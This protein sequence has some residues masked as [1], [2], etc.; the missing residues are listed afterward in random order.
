MDNWIGEGRQEWKLWREEL[1][2]GKVDGSGRLG[3]RR[4]TEV[5]DW[6]EEGQRKWKIG[7]EKVDRI[8]RL[9]GEDID[10]SGRLGGRKLTE[11]EDWGGRKIDGSGS[12]GG[13]RSTEME[14]WAGEGRWKWKTG[15]EKVDGSGRQRGRRSNPGR[16]KGV[17]LQFFRV[18]TCARRVSF[19]STNLTFV[20]TAHNE[21]TSWW[22]LCTLYSLACQVRVTVGSRGPFR[23]S[24]TLFKR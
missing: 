22:C 23:V 18:N 8:G 24:V 12:L 16:D 2:Q 19:E 14:D 9:G 13:R 15:R 20:C 11:V 1:G 3:G 6:A 4:S 5:K 10:G 7:R 21:C 17:V